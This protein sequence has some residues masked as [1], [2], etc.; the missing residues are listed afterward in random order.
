MGM[1]TEHD[2]LTALINNLGDKE[3]WTVEPSYP[4]DKEYGGVVKRAATVYRKIKYDTVLEKMCDKYCKYLATA[5]GH[6]SSDD[7]KVRNVDELERYCNKCPLKQLLSEEN[8]R[9]KK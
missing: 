3:Y 6:C 8:E 5:N 4:L 2:M 1:L 9:S 7:Y